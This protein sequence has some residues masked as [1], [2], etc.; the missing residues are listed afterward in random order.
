MLCLGLL[1]T[2]GHFLFINAL[3]VINASFAAPF[4]YLTVLLAAFWGFFLYNEIPNN[5]T[6]AGGLL[7]IIAGII[8]IRIKKK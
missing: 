4:V 5:N 7:I 6:I 2:I 3:K 1:A 8:I